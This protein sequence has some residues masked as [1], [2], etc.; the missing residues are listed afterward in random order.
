MG[1]DKREA[2]PA[3]RMNRNMQLLGMGVGGDL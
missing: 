2:Q 1:R 3:R